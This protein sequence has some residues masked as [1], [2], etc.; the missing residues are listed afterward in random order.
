MLKWGCQRF[1][2]RKGMH[3]HT[4]RDAAAGAGWVRLVTSTAIS[5]CGAERRLSSE[6]VHVAGGVESAAKQ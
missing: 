1:Q 5:P 4:D 6:Q 2:H 3:L